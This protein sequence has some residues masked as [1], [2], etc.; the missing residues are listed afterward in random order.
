M[1]EYISFSNKDFESCTGVREDAQYLHSRF[2]Q[3]FESLKS[4]D[5]FT[6]EFT[7]FSGYTARPWNQGS[8]TFRD[9]IWIGFANSKYREPRDEIQFQVSLFDNEL[10]IQLFIDKRAIKTRQRVRDI[11][12]KHH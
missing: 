10:N 8:K 7:E 1:S 11:I 2:K 5:I 9:Y 4:N 12:R 3:L 6:H